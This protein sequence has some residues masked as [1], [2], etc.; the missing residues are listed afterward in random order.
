MGHASSSSGV[1]AAGAGCAARLAKRHGKPVIAFAGCVTPDADTLNA[2]GIDAFF[3]I[4]RTVGTLEEALDVRNA[5]ANLRAAARQ[6]FRLWST[7][8]G[9]AK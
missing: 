2:H 7:A 8:K 1:G 6:A 3:P 4:L 5:A 9:T